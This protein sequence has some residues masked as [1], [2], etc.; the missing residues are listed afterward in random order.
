MADAAVAAFVGVHDNVVA[1]D[2]FAAAG[3]VA[4]VKIIEYYYL[5]KQNDRPPLPSS[6]PQLSCFALTRREIVC[7]TQPCLLYCFRFLSNE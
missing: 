4:A 7:Q 1:H 6:R 2:D 5:Q 3:A